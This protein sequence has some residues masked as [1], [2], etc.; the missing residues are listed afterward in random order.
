MSAPDTRSLLIVIPCLNEIA[1]IERLIGDLLADSA[2]FDALLVVADGGST[3]GS[4]EAVRRAAAQDARVR[5]LDNPRRI[6]SAGVNEAVRRFGA[7]RR[8]L[9]R[10]D[11]H[12]GYPPSFAA[13]VL[14][15]AERTGAQAV[16]VPMATRGL[17]CFQRAAAAAQNSVLGAGGSA[18]RKPGASGWVDHGH[19]ALMDIARFA[20]VGG[21]D[22]TFSHN[23]DAELDARLAR[24]DVGIWL[25]GD[26]V[27]TYHPRRNPL[28][29]W[30]Q[31]FGYGRG[32]ARNLRRHRRRLK[33]RQALPLAVCPA[34]ALAALT[35][36]LAPAGFPAAAWALAC[37]GFGA[38]LGA[39][40]RDRCAVLSGAAAMVMHLAWSAGFWSERIA[41]GAPVPEPSSFRVSPV[42]PAPPPT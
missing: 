31:Y 30:R 24:T 5:L 3:D 13:G 29:L 23:E 39:R 33:L 18:H 34:V 38:A 25:A 7:G 1:H 27:I 8:W 19:H 6:Q 35:P 22:E 32:R 42:E 11:A 36:W 2:A 14:A 9:L 15:A 41:G 37:L 20:A 10:A 40:A 21:Y 16:V 4:Q 28:S 17:G 12:A 26:V